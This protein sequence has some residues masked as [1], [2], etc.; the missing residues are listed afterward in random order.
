MLMGLQNI[1]ATLPTLLS[2]N[3]PTQ[4]LPYLLGRYSVTVLTLL[5][6]TIANT[7]PTILIVT[8][9]THYLSYLGAPISKLF[10]LCV[11]ISILITTHNENNFDAPDD[12][13]HREIK[14]KLTP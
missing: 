14:S 4:Y 3:I 13:V 5:S 7:I 8:L 11:V 10:S 9:P 6:D 1:R 2:D 12:R